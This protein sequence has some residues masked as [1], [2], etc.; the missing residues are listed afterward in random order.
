MRILLNKNKIKKFKILK[1][2][3][4]IIRDIEIW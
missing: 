2:I 1:Y 3:H 4:L